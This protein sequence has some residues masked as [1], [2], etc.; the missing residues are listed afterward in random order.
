MSLWFRIRRPNP[1]AK[2]SLFC[3][4]Y[5]G[6]AAAAYD[7]WPFRL[8][9]GI[10]VLAVQPPGRAERMSEAAIPSLERMTSELL[11]AIAPYLTR[12]FVFFG[13]SNG[14]LIAYE[15]ARRLQLLNI[16]GLQHVVISAKRAPHL[17]A[18]AP[19]LHAKPRHEMIESLRTY[20]GIPDE[21]LSD[22]EIIDMYLPTLRADFAISELHQ[23]VREPKLRCDATLFGGT[24]DRHVP[25]ED[26]LAWTSELSGQITHHAFSGGHFFTSTAANEVLPV[27]DHVLRGVLDKLAP[28]KGDI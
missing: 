9:S 14:A 13:H 21:I 15:L 23:H 27:L 10:E 7:T 3:F 22:G 25:E 26:L 4:P 11:R 19:P 8:T 1:D 16:G 5:A 18:I 12:P 17:P 24:L 20:N 6:G 2:L 28:R